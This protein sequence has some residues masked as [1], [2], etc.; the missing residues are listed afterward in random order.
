MDSIVLTPIAHSALVKITVAD[1]SDGQA[2][3]DG[4]FAADLASAFD[5]V[6][7]ILGLSDRNF[8]ERVE[9]MKAAYFTRNGS[10]L[11]SNE[12]VLH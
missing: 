12:S 2:H 11:Q 8:G 10:D 1:G 4:V 9:Q 7:V 6:S 3:S 5:I